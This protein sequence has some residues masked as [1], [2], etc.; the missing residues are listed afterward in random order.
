MEIYPGYEMNLADTVWRYLKPERLLQILD[1]HKIYFASAKQFE[2]NFEGAVRISPKRIKEEG[3][4]FLGELADDAFKEL[5]RLTKICCWN[6]FSYE[7]D[8]MWKLY[9]ADKKGIAIV[10]TPERIIK[11]IKDYRIKPEYGIE[12][13][14]IGKI[15][16][17][18]LETQDAEWNEIGRFFHKHSAFS[19]ENEI[20]LIISLRL[21]EEYGV[22]IPEEGI[23]VEFDIKTLIKNIV[24]GPNIENEILESLLLKCKAIGIKDRVM[25]SIL[26]LNPQ[27]I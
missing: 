27:Y 15:K 10:S 12:K 13:S 11:S 8:G 5:K 7:C 19:W 17:V 25:E 3:K 1:T 14:Y 20:R 21:A 2:D 26:K 24:L 22:S 9:A 6:Q 16:Y 23:F 18:S 4:T